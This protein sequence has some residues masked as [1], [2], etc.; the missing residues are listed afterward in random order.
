M[1]PT[2]ALYLD[3]V[4]KCLFDS[5]Y[6]NKRRERYDPIALPANPLFRLVVKIL[7]KIHI[8]LV[9]PRTVIEQS[10]DCE[11]S[12]SIAHSMSNPKRF[13]RLQN[14]VERV[15]ED[16]IPG[17]FIETGVWRGGGTILM[18]AIL[19][20][21]EVDDRKVW[22]ADSFEGLP[23]PDTET[24]PDDAGDVMHLDNTLRISLEEV[25]ANFGTYG[26]LD[27][28]VVFLKGWFRDTLPTVKGK[29][30]ALIRLDGDMYEA[31][32]DAFVNLYPSLS[33]GG[34]II[35][36][37]YERRACRQAVQDY[38]HQH[39]IVEPIQA[40]DVFEAYWRKKG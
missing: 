32:M 30:W 40:T 23:K 8:E 33:V 25:K 11:M 26:L 9:R 21:F 12:P 35:I 38:R 6:G 5:I 10:I 29:P 37:D 28:Q 17:D 36:D 13:E 22:V 18:R 1:N 4:K 20:A 2:Q 14:C 16:K 24:Y 27:D 7:R 3:L 31:T 19:R 39:Q 34:Y 15:L